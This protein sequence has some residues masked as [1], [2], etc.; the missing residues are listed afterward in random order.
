MSLKVRALALAAI[1][2]AL[3]SCP[4]HAFCEPTEEEIAAARD[5]IEGREASGMVG[6]GDDVAMIMDADNIRKRRAAVRFR[7]RLS[8][9]PR[10]VADEIRR[11]RNDECV[12]LAVYRHSLSGPRAHDYVI[13]YSNVLG[14]CGSVGCALSV[15]LNPRPGKWTDENFQVLSWRTI[16]RG[17]RTLLVTIHTGW[18]CGQSSKYPACIVTRRASRGK[19]VEI[20]RVLDRRRGR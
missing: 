19:L 8:H 7:L 2:L 15:V 20:K 17:G 9:F 13:D 14:V 12:D 3:W 4:A 10:V 5:R 1:A 16:R 6:M 11:I 18:T